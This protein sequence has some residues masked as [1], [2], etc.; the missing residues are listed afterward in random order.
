MYDGAGLFKNLQKTES[1]VKPLSRGKDLLQLVS[2]SYPK[3]V[4]ASRRKQNVRPKENEVLTFIEMDERENIEVPFKFGRFFKEYLEKIQPHAGASVSSIENSVFKNTMTGVQAHFKNRLVHEN[5]MEFILS[6][7]G[8][9]E[10]ESKKATFGELNKV[11]A[12][13]KPFKAGEAKEPGTY[14]HG[15]IEKEALKKAGFSDEE[16]DVIYYGNWLRDYS[17]VIV[18]FTLGFDKSDIDIID[19]LRSQYSNQNITDVI[20]SSMSYKPSHATWVEVFKILAVKEFIYD[21]L[22]K[23]N[24]TTTQVYKVHEENFKKKFGDFTR[25]TFGLYRPEEHIDNPKGLYDESILGDPRLKH[26]VYFNY[27]F[28]DYRTEKRKLYAGT[29][30]RSLEINEETMLKRYIKEDVDELRP[31]SFTYLKEQ[32]LLARKYGKTERGLRHLGAALHVLEDY[33]AHSNFIEIAL[34]KNGYVTVYPWVTLDDETMKIEDGKVK[35]CKIPVVTGS[36]GFADT[37]ASVAPILEEKLFPMEIDEYEQLKSGDRTFFDVLALK[38]LENLSSKQSALPSEKQE[39]YLGLTI[40]D[41]LNMYNTYLEIR[42]YW[43]KQAENKYYGWFFVLTQAGMH[44]LSESLSFHW[45]V[46]FNI[47]LRSLEAGIREEQARLNDYGTDPTHTQ[48]AKDPVDHPLNPLAGTLAT[49]AVEDVAK[50]MLQ[51]WNGTYRIDDLISYID[52]TY[53]VHPCKTNWQDIPLGNWALQNKEA[54]AKAESKT[55]WHHHEE[56][57]KKNLDEFRKT[58]ED[59]KNPPAR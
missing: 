41:I 2:Y 16:I 55:I 53:F 54:V 47:L 22:K 5:M 44:Y 45:N 20:L 26:P 13:M 28:P 4:K 3:G 48:I 42:D 7:L 1:K 34:I 14:A 18:G 32:L 31:S 59:I 49:L 46:L 9:E 33:F 11:F 8:I 58:I 43:T 29:V 15:D 35:A 57:I 24:Q 10:L 19:V 56:V 21:P 37:I 36:F 30:A 51:S 38:V 17:Q 25:D 6:T 52:K 39:R 23:K 27:T 40:P 12:S 50:K